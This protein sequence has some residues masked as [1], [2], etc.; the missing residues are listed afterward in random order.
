MSSLRPV[1]VAACLAFAPCAAIASGLEEVDAAEA[2]F[3]ARNLDNGQQAAFLEFLADDGVLFRPEAIRGRE[4]LATYESATGRLERVPL[5]TAAS[6]DGRLALGTGRWTYANAAGGELAGGHYLTVW[7]QDHEGRWRIA[8]DHRIDHSVGATAQ[9]PLAAAIAA[10]WPTEPPRTCDERAG[11]KDFSKAD[12]A[13]DKAI[14]KRGL[15]AA[16]ERASASGALVYRDDAPPTL[17]T[18]PGPAD[19]ARFGRGS[20]TRPAGTIVEPSAD[21]AVSYGIIAAPATGDRAAPVEAVYVRVWNRTARR[22]RLAIDFET[23][24]VDKGDP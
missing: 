5:A 1:I 21:V 4:W 8:L 19:D 3:A 22:W 18:K 2:A 15:P 14:G 17:L 11:S 6:C 16:L 9:A 23:P 24:L 20:K 10:L 7:R 12:A 13:L